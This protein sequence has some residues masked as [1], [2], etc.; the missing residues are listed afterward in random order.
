M[1]DRIAIVDIETS[2][3]D[4][5]RHEIWEVA[6]IVDDHEYEWMVQP[7]L[8]TAEPMALR[9]NRY[10]QRRPG[11]VSMWA[12]PFTVATTVARLTDGR[13]LVGA[14]PSFD[15]SFLDR[16]LRR[17]GECPTWSHRLVCVETLAAGYLRMLP[18]GLRKMAEKLGLVVDEDTHHTALGDCRLARDVFEAVMGKEG[19][20]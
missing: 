20:L 3:L 1:N 15:A 9:V 4:P 10:Y 16:F 2:G 13:H 17:H 8:K 19:Q 6:L 5:E 14:V 7:S 18:E 12:N 11:N